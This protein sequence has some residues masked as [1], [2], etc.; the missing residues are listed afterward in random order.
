MSFVTLEKKGPKGQKGQPPTPAPAATRVAK[1]TRA[2]PSVNLLSP[3]TLDRMAVLRLRRRFVAGGLALSVVVGGGWMLQTQRLHGAEDRLAAELAMRPALQQQVDA[4]AP[5]AAYFAALDARKR[6]A[7][8]AMATEVLFSEALT[9]LKSRTPAGLEIK[10]MT[11]SLNTTDVT[12]FGPDTNP[13]QDAYGPAPTTSA[14]AGNGTTGTPIGSTP[15]QGAV[16]SAAKT[17]D[18][19]SDLAGEEAAP[20][21]PAAKAP[22]VPVTCARP[23]PFNLAPI[24]GCVTLTGSAES[25]AVVGEFINSLKSSDMYADPFVTTTSANGEDGVQFSGSVGLTGA[26]VSG[27]YADL[28][29][30][31]DPSILAKAER[32]IAAGETA[33]AKWAAK[34]KREAAAQQIQAAAQAAAEA[35]ALADASRK[36]GSQ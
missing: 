19:P 13:L 21:K 28:R 14:P 32:M 27:R 20:A 15:V 4:L 29:W 8:Q 33:S 2:L 22:V 25:R 23:D 18:A 16:M 7:S 17:A 9:D 35:A 26:A 24:I 10:A 5:V 6:T 1:A 30:L 12:N 34:A 11:V 36:G 31:A 3:S